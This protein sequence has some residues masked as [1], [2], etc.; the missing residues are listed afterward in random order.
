MK[1]KLYKTLEEFEQSSWVKMSSDSLKI[2]EA[3]NRAPEIIR[4]M[5]GNTKCAKVRENSGVV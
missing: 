4:R 1:G 3:L 2:T 5:G